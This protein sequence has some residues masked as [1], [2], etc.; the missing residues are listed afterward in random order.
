MVYFFAIPF[1]T[2]QRGGRD[3]AFHRRTHL[4]APRRAGAA[5]AA[6]TSLALLASCTSAVG[7]RLDAADGDAVDG[8]V[9]RVGSTTDL[10]PKTLYSGG[11]TPGLTMLGNVF[12]N[13]TKY[14]HD[15]QDPQ[16]VL[17][18]SWDEEE[19]GTGDDAT[20]T[21]TVKL[22]DGVT[23]HNGE[24]LDSQ[25]V[26]ASFENY[27]DPARAGQ[28]A[29]TAQQISKIGTPDDSTVELTFGQQI[30]NI[31]DLFEFVPIIE[32]STID[33]FNAGSGFVGTGPF[34][35]DE[36]RQGNS[37]TLDANEDYRDGAPPLDGIEVVVVPDQQTQF[38]QLRSGQLDVL[39]ESVPRDAEALEDNDL[40]NVIETEGTGN[41]Y[42]TGMNV[43][44][45]TFRDKRVR[46]AVAL[47][48]DRDRILDEVYQ[49]RGYTQSLPWPEDSPAYDA[50][51]NETYQ[52]DTDRAR[53]LVEEVEAENGPLPPTTLA[54]AGESTT[55][56]NTAQILATD[57]S[58]IGIEVELE[59][60]EKGVV[61]DR[62]INSGYDGM[63]LLDH[64]FVQYAPSTLTVSAFPF[65]SE[66]NTSN[67]YDDDYKEAA[68]DA[69][70]AGD[71][72]S[73]EAKAS[74]ERLNDELLDEAFLV[75]LLRPDAPLVTSSNVHDVDWTKR[76]ELDFGDTYF[77]E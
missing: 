33:D 58:D 68:Q 10:T 46:Q 34:A 37:L 24:T 39:P 66:K 20:T 17:A 51:K 7:E 41:V 74:F 31:Y 40:F 70:T 42:Y 44:A 9:L 6:L 29:R 36:W 32:D 28:L 2:L 43:E 57:L 22:R 60:L 4:G 15:G 65:N 72:E 30:N 26:K 47:A 23:F 64:N 1:T 55:E 25:D 73:P 63:W 49:G 38:A 62:L 59:P 35:F 19:S 27:S 3:V 50:E 67:F 18:E 45:P 16:P 77:T 54:Y 12:E 69:W 8:G 71:P 61:S 53:E 76:S 5:L 11:G 13:L 75:E 21:V 52:Q 14:D 48:A 56:Q